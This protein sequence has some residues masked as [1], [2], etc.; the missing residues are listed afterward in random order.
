MRQYVAQNDTLGL[1]ELTRQSLDN[2]AKAIFCQLLKCH[3]ASMWNFKD[4][5]IAANGEHKA[6]SALKEAANVI[7]SS[8]LALQL[9]YLQT[10]CAISAEKNS[11]IIFP[12]PI[13][14]LHSSAATVN[15]KLGSSTISL[16]EGD[17]QS[18]RRKAMVR[19]WLPSLSPDH[20]V[21]P[22]PRAL[23]PG[24]GE[25]DPLIPQ[26]VPPQ[27]PE[28]QRRRYEAAAL[29]TVTGAAK[30]ATVTT[31]SPLPPAAAVETSARDSQ[32]PPQL[33]RPQLGV[34]HEDFDDT[35]SDSV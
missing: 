34:A 33:P 30:K 15:A 5:V 21:T 2:K 18:R 17:S 19:Q 26:P 9:R 32:P 8:P 31:A 25:P 20:S 14:I 28:S 16:N 22:N 23:L 1:I 27:L 7:A 3:L 13:D 4:M 10:L 11:T 12:L 24:M 29:L 35:C 6:S